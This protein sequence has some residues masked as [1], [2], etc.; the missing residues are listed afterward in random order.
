MDIFQDLDGA[1]SLVDW[2]ESSMDH[3]Y[4]LHVD[5]SVW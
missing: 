4:R 1:Q 5:A 3:R 2:E